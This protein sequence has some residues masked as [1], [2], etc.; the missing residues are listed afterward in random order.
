MSLEAQKSKEKAKSRSPLSNI[1]LVD[2]AMA[3]RSAGGE[4]SGEGQA[5][6]QRNSP[7]HLKGMREYFRPLTAGR[8]VG[9]VRLTA[10]RTRDAGQVRTLDPTRDADFAELVSSVKSQGVLQPV[11]LSWDPH[12]D[13]FWVDYGHR[14]VAA[15]RAA[16][17]EVVPATINQGTDAPADISSELTQKQ[18]IENLQRTQ[19]PALD[20][21]HALKRLTGAGMTAVAVAS[22]LGKSKSWVSKHLKLLELPDSILKRA[23]A[24]NLGQE[25]L[26]T[27][28]QAPGDEAERTRLLDV[29]LAGGRPALSKAIDKSV[30]S[31]KFA[32]STAAP[33]PATSDEV[34]TVSRRAVLGAMRSVGRNLEHLK[35]LLDLDA[36]AEDCGIPLAIDN[37]LA[38]LHRYRR[39]AQS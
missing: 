32:G 4:S 29:A 23:E 3:V 26:Y 37:L 6:S 36:A 19:L 11:T 22:Q 24:A 21:A 12:S 16:G 35:E 34:Q 10:V 8:R 17:L 14:R 28:A 1:N 30:V 25:I 33:A 9:E 15:A 13:C 7:E 27:L 39:P 18:L 2:Q 31:G 5:V 38:S 20:V